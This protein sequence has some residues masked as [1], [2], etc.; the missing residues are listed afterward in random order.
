M[1][2]LKTALPI[3]IFLTGACA[4]TNPPTRQ[5]T[6]TETVIRQ[7]DQIGAGDYAPLE[8]RQARQK[9]EQAHAAYNNEDYEEAARLAEQAKVDAEL[10]QIK[11]LSGKAQLAVRELRESIRLLEE[12]LSKRDGEN[13]E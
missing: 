11:T 12:E 13:K 1:N 4:S 3:L 2:V 6:E 9:L 10:A 8:I 7:A 5:L